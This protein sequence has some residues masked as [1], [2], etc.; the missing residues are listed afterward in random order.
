MKNIFSQSEEEPPAS[1]DLT[2][3]GSRLNAKKN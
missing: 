1:V 3:N 2:L